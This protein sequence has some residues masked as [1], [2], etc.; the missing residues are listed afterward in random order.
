M[1]QSNEIDFLAQSDPLITKIGPGAFQV[2]AHLICK[3]EAVNGGLE[4]KTSSRSAAAATGQSPDTVRLNFRKL[5]RHGVVSGQISPRGCQFIIS[6]PVLA[7]WP[8]G[9]PAAGDRDP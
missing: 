9:R 5:L 2:L 4:V 6:Q 1:T 7:E 8:D 3:A